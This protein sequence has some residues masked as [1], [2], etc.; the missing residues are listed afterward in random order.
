MKSK[1]TAP[2]AVCAQFEEWRAPRRGNSNPENQTNDVWRWLVDNPVWPLRAHQA[3]GAPQKNYPTWCFSRY[4]QSE[5]CLPNGSVVYIGGEHEDSYDPDFY[6]YNDVV[7]V[8]PDTSIEIFGYPTHVFP[9]TDFHSATLVDQ[10]IYIIGG[11]RYPEDRDYRNTLV[12]RLDLTDFSIHLT[13][14]QGNPPCWLYKHKATFDPYAGKIICTEGVST[15]QQTQMDVENL[16][17]WE[18]ALQTRSW[19]EKDTKPYRRWLL[20]RNDGSRNKLWELKVIADASRSLRQSSL[21]EKYLRNFEERGHTVDTELYFSRFQPPIPHVKIDRNADQ[22]DVR[23]HRILVDGVVV[24]YVENRYEIAVTVEGDLSSEKLEL[25]KS[26]GLDTYSRLEG[27][28]YK[29]LML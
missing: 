18:F 1:I 9:P 14:T 17:T 2:E 11:L 4:G 10:S 3:V 20:V 21:A 15:H 16:T 6:I 23:A 27:V 24:R 7:V 19:E 8:R 26:H 25:L 28:R 12:Y 29:C 13:P 5:T 22:R